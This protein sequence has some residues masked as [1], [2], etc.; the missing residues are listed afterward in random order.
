MMIIMIVMI[1]NYDEEDNN[2]DTD[3][4]MKMISM[5]LDTYRDEYRRCGC[6]LV[7][8]YHGEYRRHLTLTSPC[9]EQSRGG[10][11]DTIHSSKC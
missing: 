10:Q 4:M 3:V 8:L 11:E 2:D 5:L 6:H 1:I 7:D 9:I